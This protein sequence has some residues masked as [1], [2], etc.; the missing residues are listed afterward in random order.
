[1]RLPLCVSNLPLP[2]TKITYLNQVAFQ[3]QL[4]ISTEMN[5]MLHLAG[6]SGQTRFLG[7]IP[8]FFT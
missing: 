6:P 3:A 2:N 1:M 8:K 5:P 7:A 4:K